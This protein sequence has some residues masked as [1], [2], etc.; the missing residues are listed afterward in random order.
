MICWRCMPRGGKGRASSLPPLA[1]QYPAYAAR[2]RA[3]MEQ[4][5]FAARLDY[6]RKRLAGVPA[7]IALPFDRP[8][9]PQPLRRGRREQMRLEPE[10]VDALRGL[11][12]RNGATLYMVL[13]AGLQALL[14]RYSGQT[15][16]VVGSPIA[17]R[18]RSELE[19]LVGFFVNTLAM[20]ADVSGDPYV[21]RVF[22][23]GCARRRLTP[24]PTRTC[25]SS[26]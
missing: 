4:P 6:W 26:G 18:T 14:H 12:R 1:I 7:E 24:M 10:L 23:A 20:R 9:L 3:A 16:F 25:R 11:A 15:D 13:L 5:D 2:Q 21:P 17:G 8:R 22:S 19:Q